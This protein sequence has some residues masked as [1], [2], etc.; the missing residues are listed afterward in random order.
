MPNAELAQQ[1]LAAIEENPASFESAL[2]GFATVASHAIW[3]EDPITEDVV[4]GIAAW[5]C[6]L[7]GWYLTDD[8]MGQPYAYQLNDPDEQ[9]HDHVELAAK[10]LGLDCLDLLD[11]DDHDAALAGLR[12]IAGL[13]EAEPVDEGAQACDCHGAWHA[14]RD[15]CRTWPCASCTTICA[16]PAP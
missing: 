15:H 4:M 1:I 16:A 9:G 12:A 3:P 7:S 2:K 11:E 13:P 14:V 8:Q 6:H 5:A 10:L